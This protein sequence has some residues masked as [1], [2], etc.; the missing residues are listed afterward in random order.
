MC[1]NNDDV[2]KE[3]LTLCFWRIKMFT[4]ILVVL[5]V[6]KENTSIKSGF[7]WNHIK[8]NFMS[9]ESKKNVIHNIMCVSTIIVDQGH[10]SKLN[11][12]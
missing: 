1:F 3:I 9:N 10:L 6:E 12:H 2:H 8:T 5:D 4:H 11:V 7:I